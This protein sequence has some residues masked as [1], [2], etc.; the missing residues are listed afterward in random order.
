M[1]AQT[2][3]QPISSLHSETAHALA[4][5]RYETAPEDYK[6]Y[7][8]PD[9][10]EETIRF[11][12]VDAGTIPTGDVMIFRFGKTADF[13]YRNEIAQVT[14]HEW[15]MIQEGTIRLPFNWPVKSAQLIPRSHKSRP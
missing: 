14:P 2:T 13:P 6:I 8:F 10:R 1:S 11:I 5:S 9:D 4:A 7:W 15:E 12:E 3:T